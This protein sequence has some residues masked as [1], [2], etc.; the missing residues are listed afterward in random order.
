MAILS[1]WRFSIW[2]SNDRA[3]GRYEPNSRGL[4]ISTHTFSVRDISPKRD[5]LPASFVRRIPGCIEVVRSSF[6]AAE[7]ASLTP[8]CPKQQ[9][10]DAVGD[11]ERNGDLTP[12]DTPLVSSAAAC[13]DTADNEKCIS[14]RYSGRHKIKSILALI[15]FESTLVFALNLRWRSL[16]APDS[17]HRRAADRMPGRP[18]RDDSST[19]LSAVP[20]D[21]CDG[22]HC[23]QCHA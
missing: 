10:T 4:G 21:L 11:Y 7:P 23:L 15:V 2:G 3:A 5:S 22:S 1:N 19:D 12:T 18:S 6:S 20:G 14:C 9:V 17:V 13:S 8:F 16:R